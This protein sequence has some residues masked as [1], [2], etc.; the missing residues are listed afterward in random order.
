MSSPRRFRPNVPTPVPAQPKPKLKKKRCRNCD[1]KFQLTKPNRKF[2]STNCKNE[3]ARF[4]SA[5]GPLRTHIETM[6]TRH[7]KE[8]R[9][10]V[11]KVAKDLQAAIVRIEA[12]EKFLAELE[13]S[14]EAPQKN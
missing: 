1:A 10:E 3:F 8:I 14:E 7:T 2:C 11:V 5:F 12:M 6:M 9:G 13:W 4:G